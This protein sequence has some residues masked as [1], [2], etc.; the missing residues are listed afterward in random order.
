MRISEDVREWAKKEGITPEE[1]RE[2]GM[3]ERSREF[4]AGGG[5][6]YR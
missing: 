2:R 1:A 4:L 5:E 3:K 6:L